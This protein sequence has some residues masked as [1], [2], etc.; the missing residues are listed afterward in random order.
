MRL[1]MRGCKNRKQISKG[2]QGRKFCKVIIRTV[3][4]VMKMNMN[5]APEVIPRD[6]KGKYISTFT[7]DN[8]HL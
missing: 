8:E 5:L 2:K 4:G 3:D 1:P 7:P 6:L